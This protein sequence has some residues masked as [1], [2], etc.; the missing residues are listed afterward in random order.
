MDDQEDE[1]LEGLNPTQRARRES[2]LVDDVD[3]V[4]VILEN[5]RTHGA[6]QG[7]KDERIDFVDVVN[8]NGTNLHAEG[9]FVEVSESGEE[10][11]RRVGIQIGPEY[12]ARLLLT[13]TPRI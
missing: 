4:N 3:Y 11:Q 7:N 10:V 9:V 1:I 2:P 12:P 13:P 8:W 6:Q 5:L